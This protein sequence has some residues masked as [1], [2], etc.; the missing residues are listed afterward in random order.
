MVESIK[1]DSQ[2]QAG[3]VDD[4]FESMLKMNTTE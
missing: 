1:I 3:E 4:D 2:E